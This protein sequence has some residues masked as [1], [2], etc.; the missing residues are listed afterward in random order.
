MLIVEEESITLIITQ[1]R[2][3]GVVLPKNIYKCLTIGG[4]SKETCKTKDKYGSDVTAKTLRL[5]V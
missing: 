1:E 5:E 2:P 3:L 4:T